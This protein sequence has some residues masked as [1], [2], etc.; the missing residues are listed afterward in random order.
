MKPPYKIAFM[1]TPALAVPTLK[2]LI[3]DPNFDVVAVVTQPDRPV[4]RSHT[5]QPS[6]I[7][8]LA[9]EHQVPVL[10]PER[11]KKNE[12]LLAKLRAMALDAIV[13]MAYGKILPQELLDIP[14]LGVVN[15][16]PSL[17]PKHRGVQ[18]IVASI[19]AGDAETGVTI[20]KL[21]IEMDAGPI[22]AFSEPLPLSKSETAATLTP[23]LA[24]LG[25]QALLEVLPRYLAGETE[26]VEQD[27]DQ[28]TFV[29][30]IKKEDGHINWQNPAELIERQV[31]AYNPWPTAFTYFNNQL[32]KVME[33]EVLDITNSTPGTVHLTDDGFPA[34]TTSEKSVKLLVVHLAGKKPMS[35]SDFLKGNPNFVDSV[36]I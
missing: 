34:V 21:V 22:I 15:V 16:H 25:A 8:R 4:G 30:L 32:L 24:D 23:K 5:P 29:Q 19:L 7:K 27:H 2:G 17:L 28:A 20:I 13:L 6:P 31:R 3:E 12:E 1:G 35:G 14:R 26:L 18:P 9:D 10:T 33:A 36:L 11:V